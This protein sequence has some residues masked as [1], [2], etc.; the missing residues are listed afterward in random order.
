MLMLFGKGNVFTGV[1]LFTAEEGRVSRSLD[2]SYD[3][4]PPDMGPG[5][6]TTSPG[7]GSGHGTL[8]PYALLLVTSGGHH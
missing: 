5:C 6:P 2:M 3:R 8:M 4:I 1:C 7:H